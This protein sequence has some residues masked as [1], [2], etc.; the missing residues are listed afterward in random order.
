M[1]RVKPFDFLAGRSNVELLEAALRRTGLD[2]FSE[3]RDRVRCGCA[4]LDD[5]VDLVWS[6]SWWPDGQTQ[7]DSTISVVH[8][9]AVVGRCD[10]A[11]LLRQKHPESLPVM[12]VN[13][14]ARSCGMLTGKS[15]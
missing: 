10:V 9:G 6:R 12:I 14:L 5:P 1:T 15:P 8:R 3:T 13:E 4:W 11:A 2:I 7:E